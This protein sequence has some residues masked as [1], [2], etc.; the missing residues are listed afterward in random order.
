MTLP[1]QLQQI[2]QT[3]IKLLGE[4]ISILAASGVPSMQEQLSNYKPLLQEAGISESAWNSIVTTSMAALASVP[5]LPCE[6][7][8][9]T[10]TVVG[11]KGMMGRF[12]TNRLSAAGHQV[13]VLEYDGW[14]DAEVLLG[15]ADL[16]LICV[17]LKAMIAVMQRVTPF[18]SPTTLLADIASTKTAVVQAMLASH[19]GPVMGLHPMF[20]PGIQSFLAQKVVA[21]PG[22]QPEAFGWL[23]DLIEADGGKL[24]TCTPEEH[25][26]MMI[27][28]QAIRHFSSFSLGVF[29]AEEGIAI[30]QSLEFASPIYRSEI[31]MISRLFAQDGS[32]YID[33]MLASGDRR[34][35]IQRLVE[36]CDRLANLLAQ[37]NRSALIAEFETASQAFREESNRALQESN[38]VINSLSTF[39]SASEVEANQLLAANLYGTR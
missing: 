2:D 12:F 13:N 39:L 21:C 17:P 20:G 24:I 27:A 33:I 3:L 22:R 31:N 37:R 35:A 1:E 26:R 16:V 10:I 29:L 34:E 9:R 14:A 36:T 5:C 32:L 23:L 28:V 4:R 8:R 18:L 25:D 19:T 15:N 38:H 11:G 6:T 7:E 30:D